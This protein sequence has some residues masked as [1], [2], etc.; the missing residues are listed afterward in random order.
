[1]QLFPICRYNKNESKI[2]RLNVSVRC[3]V[4][5]MHA[6]TRV[7]HENMKKKKNK[8][9]N[10]YSNLSVLDVRFDTYRGRFPTDLPGV[11]WYSSV[12]HGHRRAHTLHT[13]NM[14]RERGSSMPMRSLTSDSATLCMC[15]RRMR[16]CDRETLPATTSIYIHRETRARSHTMFQCEV[17]ALEERTS[18]V[19]QYSKISTLS[20]D[21]CRETDVVLDM[22]LFVLPI[23]CVFLSKYGHC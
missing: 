21:R 18:A 9:K 4:R 16:C 13:G 10:K 1:M 7:K 2:V 20:S 22:F 23:S 15:E 6:F 14:R 12:R 19:Q 8:F 5:R 3:T 11:L 17:H